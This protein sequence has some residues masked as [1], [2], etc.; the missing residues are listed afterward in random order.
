MG[1]MGLSHMGI[2]MGMSMPNLNLPPTTLSTKGQTREIPLYYLY[3][4]SLLLLGVS[5]YAA[6]LAD[7]SGRVVFINICY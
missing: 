2:P 5:Y 1:R 4:L 6:V 7:L 3:Y